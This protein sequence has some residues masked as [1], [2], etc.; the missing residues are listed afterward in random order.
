[1]VLYRVGS[2]ADVPTGY[3]YQGL[4]FNGANL[5]LAGGN[6]GSLTGTVWSVPVVRSGGHIAGFGTAASFADVT[7]ADL[8]SIGNV[9]AGGLVVSSGTLFYTTKSVSFLG[10]YYTGTSSLTDLTALAPG[11]LTGGLSFVPNTSQLRASSTD[12]NWYDVNLTGSPGFYTVSLSTPFSL[13]VPADSFVYVPI[14]AKILQPSAVVGDSA[15]DVLRL[16]GL[17][18]NGNPTGTPQPLIQGEGLIIGY[19][20]TRDPLTGDWLF[21]TS[22]NDI[23][24]ASDTIPEPATL[25]LAIGGIALL[26]A[27]RR[28]L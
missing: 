7:M 9:V 28:R 27:L 22:N 13:G 3:S 16:Y 1:M 17:D 11:I 23:W 19:G 14:D 5:L 10:Q 20:V 6:P 25:A 26:A 21:T 8:S 2:V 24:L 4:S 18:A 12:G 15:S